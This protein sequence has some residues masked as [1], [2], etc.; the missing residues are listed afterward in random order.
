MKRDLQRVLDEVYRRRFSLLIVCM[1]V[2]VLADSVKNRDYVLPGIGERVTAAQP[3]PRSGDP[4]RRSHRLPG[5]VPTGF[6]T[7]LMQDPAIAPR[8]A[9]WG[10]PADN[11]VD[12]MFWHRSL[13]P[14]FEDALECSLGM[15]SI[16]GRRLD[17]KTDSAWCSSRQRT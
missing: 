6:Y 9:G 1:V 3:Q 7:A 12:E 16:G 17:R 8:L 10:G 5:Q 13:P 15:P 4:Q 14:A 2:F 11:D